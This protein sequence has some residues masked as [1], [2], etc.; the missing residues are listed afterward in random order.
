MNNI[1]A[2]TPYAGCPDSSAA[3]GNT[4]SIN[5]GRGMSLTV[6]GSLLTVRMKGNATT[7]YTW[8]CKI[9]DSSVLTCESRDYS[10]NSHPR[11]MV[12]VPGVQSYKFK[13]ASAGTASLIFTYA[14]SW[15]SGNPADEKSVRVT[16]DASGNILA[17]IISAQT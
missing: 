15:E 1:S 2:D 5:D 4:V 17:D 11:G 12:G 10:E 7:G 13:S 16:V 6:R 3:S 8:S 14:R 9:S